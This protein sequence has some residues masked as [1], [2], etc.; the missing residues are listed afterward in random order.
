MEKLEIKDKPIMLARTNDKDGGENW[1]N[2]VSTGIIAL[3]EYFNDLKS[4]I[5]GHTL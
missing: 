3:N 1:K 5:H 2:D 4:Y